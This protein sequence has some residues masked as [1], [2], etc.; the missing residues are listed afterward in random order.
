MSEKN[1]MLT[2]IVDREIGRDVIKVARKAGA[3][4]ATSLHGRGGLSLVDGNNALHVPIDSQKD[5]VIMIVPKSQ[6]SN[7]SKRI[8][9]SLDFEKPGTGIIFASEVNRATGLYNKGISEEIE[10]F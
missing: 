4:G 8:G 10:E 1:V 5:I 9:E 3:V 6:A 7:I 2:A